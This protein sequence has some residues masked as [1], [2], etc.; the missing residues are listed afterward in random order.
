MKRLLCKISS[1]NENALGGPVSRNNGT[2]ALNKDGNGALSSMLRTASENFASSRAQAFVWA[3]NSSAENSAALH[4]RRLLLL[5]CRLGV[6]RALGLRLVYLR[7]HCG[8]RAMIRERDP[9]TDR[10]RNARVTRNRIH[11]EF[12][13]LTLGESQTF[14]S[15]SRIG[16]IAA[17]GVL[18]GGTTSGMGAIEVCESWGCSIRVAMSIAVKSSAPARK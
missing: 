10:N 15:E 8:E 4:L 1:A 2:S 11:S 9:G 18:S 13:S 5:L 7:G 16:A 12:Q 14:S 3:R 17:D 6:K